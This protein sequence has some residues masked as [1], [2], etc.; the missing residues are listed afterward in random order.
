M[1]THGKHKCTHPGCRQNAYLTLIHHKT[2]EPWAHL[3]TLHRLEHE[4]YCKDVILSRTQE[5]YTPRERKDRTIKHTAKRRR[6]RMAHNGVLNKQAIP[7]YYP[8]KP[9]KKQIAEEE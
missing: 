9:K 7:A 4:A 5:G 1:R 3:C 6:M 2:K 8:R